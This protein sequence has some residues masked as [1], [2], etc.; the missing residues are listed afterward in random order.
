MQEYL[1]FQRSNTIFDIIQER[2]NYEK[3]RKLITNAFSFKIILLSI[4]RKYEY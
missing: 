1:N 2:M 3:N 4:L